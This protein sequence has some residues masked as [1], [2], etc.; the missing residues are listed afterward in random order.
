MVTYLVFTSFMWWDTPD[1]ISHI[2]ERTSLL[3]FI[4]IAQGAGIVNSSIAIFHRERA[5][6]QRERA[7]KMYRVLP[8]FLAK[9]LSDMTNNIVLPMT[10]GIVTYWS[11]G[12]NPSPAAF[13]K[14]VLGFY[15]SIGCAQS[16]GFLIS[17]V[18]PNINV[19][20]ILATP[21]TLFSYIA[22][23][24]YIPFNRMHVAIRS[25]S[26]VSFARYAYSA[27]VINEFQYRFVPCDDYNITATTTDANVVVIDSGTAGTMYGSS[28]LC[29]LPGEYVYKSIGLDGIFTSYWFNVAILAIF[30]LSFMVGAYVQLRRTK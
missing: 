17:I 24:F 29:P 1:D 5:L 11:A 14:F 3:F 13:F 12:L 30:Q 25:I 4:L 10:Y 20:M 23:G 28:D 21:L 19:A 9:V 15:V 6:L 7:K 2:F 27:L 18:I 22:G 16:M 8:F 26:Y